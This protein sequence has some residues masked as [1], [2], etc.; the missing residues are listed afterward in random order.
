MIEATIDNMSN[1]TIKELIILGD[2][3]CDMS[4]SRTNKITYLSSSYNLTHYTEHSS[5][6]INLV[7]VN[8]PENV[9]YSGVS[10][11]FIPNLVRYYCPT[12]LYLKHRKIVRKTFRR[13]I[14]LYDK[15]DYVKY[16]N[17]LNRIDWDHML[18]TDDVNKCVEQFSDSIMLA[19][20]EPIPNKIVTVRPSEPSWIKIQI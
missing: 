18:A 4:S 10:S 3:N 9:L 19:A 2:F 15:G 1:S 8:K 6:T 7:L 5:S 16:R 13:H 17:K 12:V 14:C 20:R 11:P